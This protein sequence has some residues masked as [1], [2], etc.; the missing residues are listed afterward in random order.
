AHRRADPKALLLF[1]ARCV[2][3]IRICFP[4]QPGVCN[5]I[6]EPKAIAGLCSLHASRNFRHR[7]NLGQRSASRTTAPLPAFRGWKL[8]QLLFT[9]P[10]VHAAV[11]LGTVPKTPAP[12][13]DLQL[14]AQLHDRFS[15]DSSPAGTSLSIYGGANRTC[16]QPGFSTRWGS[17]ACSLVYFVMY[18]T[19]RYWNI[20]FGLLRK[21]SSNAAIRAHAGGTGPPAPIRRR[22]KKGRSPSSSPARER[23]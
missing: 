14:H 8:L 10:A 13:A 17:A 15:I 19:R 5:S 21:L 1:A 7:P 9:I 18:S 20:R 12:F 11:C 16:R 22:I 4:A 23:P 6:P 3:P 2:P